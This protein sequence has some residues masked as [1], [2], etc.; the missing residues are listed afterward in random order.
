[1]LIAIKLNPE[2]SCS[3]DQKTAMQIYNQINLELVSGRYSFIPDQREVEDRTNLN[4]DAKQQNYYGLTNI[5]L[6][7][8]SLQ[9]AERYIAETNWVP[10]KT[11]LY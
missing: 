3:S 1:M 9:L 6:Q 4:V 10:S 5:R 11:I 7:K 2:L 8:Q